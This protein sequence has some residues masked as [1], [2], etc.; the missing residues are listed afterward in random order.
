MDVKKNDIK[1]LKIVF[2]VGVMLLAVQKFDSILLFLNKLLSV[3]S[4][5]FIG[6]FIAYF[7]NLL[8][9]VIE[10]RVLPKPAT[11]KKKNLYR[12]LSILF[13]FIIVIIIFSIL[14]NLIIPELMN[15]ISTFMKVIP[16]A[17]NQASDFANKYSKQFPTVEKYLASKPDLST[18]IVDN[19]DS[20]F[21]YLTTNS[22][23]VIGSVFGKIATLVMGFIIAIYILFDK[24]DLKIKFSRLF[25]RYLGEKMERKIYYVSKIA[26]ESLRAY[27]IG[28]TL[29]AII[30]GVLCTVGLYVF[31]FPYA[32]MIGVVV[33]FTGLIPVLG[34]YIGGVFG[35]FM[36][37]SKSPTQ[38][39]LFLVFLLVLQQL[40]NNLIYPRVVGGS[41]GL[42]G[43][44]VVISILIA[45]GFF[46]L[47][48]VFLSVPIAATIYKIITDDVRAYEGRRAIAD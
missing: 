30:L 27:L 31:K 13:S 9:R 28:Q 8:V 3:M 43:I 18:S 29:E 34:A 40:E 1:I 44:W 20:I 26:N 7:L 42:P 36:V 14:L 19:I 15:A 39:M 24:E 48:G 21:K 38:A 33:G 41:V 45:G 5:V 17:I 35:F 22:I 6:F 32:V 10:A 25:H 16:Q 2:I 37:L 47:V 4:T 46:G 23:L 11:I 12:S